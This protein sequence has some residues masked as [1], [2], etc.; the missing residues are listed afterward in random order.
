MICPLP[1]T[2]MRSFVKDHCPSRLD[3]TEDPRHCLIGKLFAS[4]VVEHGKIL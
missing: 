1:S 3:D 2:Q 4:I